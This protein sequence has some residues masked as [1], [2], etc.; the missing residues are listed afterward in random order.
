MD[1][2]YMLK[3]QTKI[4]TFNIQPCA[5]FIALFHEIIVMRT[6]SQNFRT[7]FT[8]KAQHKQKK[9]YP[10]YELPKLRYLRPCPAQQFTR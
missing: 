5:L 8:N 2:H 4:C 7:E 3:V 10:D 9:H 6:S 1:Y